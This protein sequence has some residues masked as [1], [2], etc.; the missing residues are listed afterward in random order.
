MASV[1]KLAIALLCCELLDLNSI[2]TIGTMPGNLGGSSGALAFGE[3][4]PV[5][6]LLYDLM[7]PS[8]NFA[9]YTLGQFIGTTILGAAAGAAAN[10]AVIALMNSRVAQLGCDDTHYLD[11]SGQINRTNQTG[12]YTTCNDL[13]M[14]AMA[15]LDRPEL[16]DPMMRGVYTPSSSGVLKT[17][18]WVQENYNVGLYPGCLGCKE[19]YTPETG[20]SLAMY[21]ERGNSALISC[22]LWWPGGAG[23]YQH[24]RDMHDYGYSML[25]E[26]AQ[27]ESIVEEANPAIVYAGTWSTSGY[28]PGFY[29]DGY[30]KYTSTIG[31]SVTLPFRG[32][33]CDW[34][35]AKGSTRGKADCSVD[36]GI[37]QRVTATDAASSGMQTLFSIDG[38]P[39]GEHTM[40]VTAAGGGIIDIDAF[41]LRAHL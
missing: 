16:R 37:K 40:T 35:G 41:R 33:G 10:A 8:D 24:G 2:V 9:A 38:L 6:E 12:H 19:G 39:F 7:L 23:V 13:M 4:Y 34:I 20:Q 32:T 36:G 17:H 29:S 28:F 18:K 11:T 26:T 30:A 31:A 1:T 22:T 25:G 5:R 14:L 21:S 27:A 15:A 3:T